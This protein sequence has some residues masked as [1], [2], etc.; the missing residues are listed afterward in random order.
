MSVRLRLSTLLREYSGAPGVVEA[1]GETVRACLDDLARRFP[2]AAK[3]VGAGGARPLVLVTLRGQAVPPQALDRG[4][5]DGEEL[6]LLLPLGG[7]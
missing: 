2:Q 4:I 3:W 6:Y 1:E 7:G 5:G